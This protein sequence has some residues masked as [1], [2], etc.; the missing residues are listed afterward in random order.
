MIGF[1]W[2]LS[3]KTFTGFYANLSRCNYTNS[4]NGC[5]SVHDTELVA[6]KSEPRN[7]TQLRLCTFS[8][9]DIEVKFITYVGRDLKSLVIIGQ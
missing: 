2:I 6:A 4:A 9:F 5:G 7:V 8:L 1:D 3:S